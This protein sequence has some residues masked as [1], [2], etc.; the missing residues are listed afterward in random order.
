MMVTSNHNFQP[1]TLPRFAGKRVRIFV[2]NDTSGHRAASRWQATLE[3][4]AREV[5]AFSF[6]GILTRHG[7]AVNDLNGFAQCEAT[8]ENEKLLADL[9]P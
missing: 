9:L 2:H 3:P 8:D 1:H 4:H 7:K 6:A 5:D